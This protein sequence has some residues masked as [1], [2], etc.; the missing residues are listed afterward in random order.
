[1]IQINDRNLLGKIIAD[2]LVK[3]N[4]NT[5]LNTAEKLRWVNAI[6]KAAL[7]IENSKDYIFNYDLENETLTIWK[8]VKNN[9]GL[10]KKDGSCDCL[11]YIANQPC[12]HRAAGQLYKNYLEAENQPLPPVSS[13]AAFA[14]EAKNALYSKTVFNK[15]ERIGG[16]AI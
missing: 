3:I 11:A 12:W 9:L 4:S 14:A 15:S 8:V 16:F 10:V 6:A 13:G 2:S 1:M 7:R 5:D